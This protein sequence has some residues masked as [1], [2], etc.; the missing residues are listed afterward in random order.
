MDIF[1]PGQDITSDWGV[2][3]D[4]SINTISGTS[5]ATPHVTGSVARY[6]QVNPSATPAQVA[7]A[8][9]TNATMNKVTNPGTGSPNRLLYNGFIDVVANQPPVASFTFTC[10]G[11]TCNFN[12]SGSTDDVAITARR[13]LFGDG[14]KSVNVVSPSH[15]YATAGTFNVELDVQ[16]GGGLT[17]TQI[18]AVTVTGGGG[19]QPPVA[20]FTF[21]CSGRTCTFDSSGSTDDVGITQ[22][23]WQFGD[24]T[25]A[26]TTVA[27]HTY[28]TGGTF[29][30]QLD[31]MD[32][33][34]LIGTTTKSVTVP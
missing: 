34:G 20:S 11:L 14:T 8:L 13:F 1:A 15:T 26:F 24:G 17:G 6:L 5:M 29:T 19:N 23:R 27:T 12:S 33:G 3:N 18:Q 9:F 2:G 16:D 30:V 25:K 32:G 4:N 7:N 28:A 31:V 22:R 21:S 10:T